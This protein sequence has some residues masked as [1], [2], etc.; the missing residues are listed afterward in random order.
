MRNK[1]NSVD[2]EKFQ[3][4]KVLSISFAHFVHDIY[5]SFLAPIL[6][7][8]IEKLGISY[9]LAGAL[10]I[11]QRIPFLLN[12]L[13]GIIADKAP[14]RYFVIVTPLITAIAMS[15]LGAAP[16]YTVLAILLFVMGL[17]AAFFHVPGPVIV[18][19]VSGNQV[20]KGMSFYMLGGE[21]ARTLGPLIILG[22]ISIWGL[23][24][25]YK[26]IPFAIL[27]TIIIYYKLK[28]IDASHSH[29]QLKAKET[30]VKKTFIKL[31]PVFLILSGLTFFRQFM[32]SALTTFLPVYMT[33][34]KEESIWVAG[35][36]LSIVEIA[37]VL[38]TLY[39][40]SLSDKLGRKRILLF[41][42]ILTPFLMLG[43]VYTSGIIMF[44]LLVLTGFTLFLTSPVLLAYVQEI[45]SEHPSFVNGVY[46]ML[47]FGW[48]AITIMFIGIFSDTLG[49]IMTFQISALLALLAI[50]FVFLLKEKK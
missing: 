13:V 5:S 42:A 24:G 49:M 18:K 6:P 9:S 8:L 23:E 4:A 3:T 32:K 39:G 19:R 29:I 12:P 36:S 48:G 45:D 7:L 11:F 30:G 1:S 41:S 27:A 44:A 43:F 34:V 14:V 10:S 35:I 15:L 2:T 33:D 16:N 46:M 20:G 38:G 31:I 26:L 22:A 21:I 25:T 40:G 28:K 47:S 17:S 37:G 50:P